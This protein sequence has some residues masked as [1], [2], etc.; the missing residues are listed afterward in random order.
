MKLKYLILIF[1]L[2]AYGAP[3]IGLANGL[4]LSVL[5]SYDALERSNKGEKDEQ[6]TQAISTPPKIRLKAMKDA[7]LSLGAQHG[8]IQWLGTLKKQ[9]TENAVSLDRIFD[10]NSLM[11]LASTG[12]S[13]LYLLPAIIRE[14][15]NVVALSDNS[16]HLRIS[17]K[18]YEIVQEERLVGMA[19]NWRTY[20]LIDNDVLMPIPNKALLPKTHEEKE[21]WKEW[22]A[23]GSAVV[24][25]LKLV[26]FENEN[27]P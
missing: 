24:L 15:N 4:P 5:Q 10:F 22:V 1:A 2:A 12:D 16:K 6:S 13:E 7:A 18:I 26:E 17:G 19:P 8:Y 14:S 11:K 25:P 23:Y 20:L 9:I 27:W 3:T 21:A